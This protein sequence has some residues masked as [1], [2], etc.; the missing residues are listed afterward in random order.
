MREK[1]FESFEEQLKKTLILYL[2]IPITFFA[3][4]GYGIM[5][6]LGYNSIKHQN[7][8]NT[9][10][11]AEKLDKIILGYYYEINKISKDKDI[12]DV[13][14]KNN[15]NN[16]IYAK[17][18]DSINS[19]G[20]DGNFII[21]DKNCLPVMYSAS[22]ILGIDNAYNFQIFSKM[23]KHPYNIILKTN[24][25]Y[26]KNGNRSI[27]SIGKAII[28]DEKIIGFIIYNMLEKHLKEIIGKGSS[29]NIVVTDKYGNI[30]TTTN[31][32]FKNNLGKIN[33]ELR[34]SF[35]YRKMNDH[36][37]FVNR[38][39]IYKGKMILYLISETSY[40]VENYINGFLY[41]IALLLVI[42]ILMYYAAKI[43]SI[44]K[45]KSMKE[46]IDAI[47]RIKIGDLNTKLNVNSNDEFE[48]I[49]SSYNKMLLNIKNLIKINE[50]K[51]K[52]NTL[53][54]IKQ[55]ESQFNPHFLF[56]TLEMLRY[57]IK[58]DVLMANKIILNI[59]SLLRF[60][61]EN[62][63]TEV[64]LELN[65]HY[66]RNYLDIQKYR[67]G[68]NFDYV[69]DIK[70]E[71]NNFLIPKLIIQ[72]IIENAIK[73]GYRQIDKMIIYIRV[74]IIKNKLVITIYNNGQGMTKNI[75]SEVRKS[76]KK[77]DISLKKHI[78][79]YNIFRRIQLMYGE[80]YGIKILSS[81]KRGTSIRLYLPIKTRESD[82]K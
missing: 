22:K 37:Y 64:P 36:K 39:E 56:N 6:F 77:D 65:S 43:I 33:K 19:L 78:G 21:Y 79:I 66:T 67:F 14:I 82:E 24:K 8:K 63:Y 13:I 23:L 1:K 70:N 30:V 54:E 2:L 4:S 46:I 71:M 62:K 42:I 15:P 75:I 47:D 7:I 38:K 10:I 29:F 52:Y 41:L 50:E 5:Y 76:L 20:I 26:F 72:P 55:L 27:L 16:K 60:S 53:L 58:T 61:I 74:K 25:I 12:M 44:N 17:V 11:L 34:D 18:Y 73:H 80:E 57:T 68:Q 3:I 45:M 35:G 40:L 49:A 28:K 69:I 51:A 81:V 31:E 9:K 32:S 59:S 48:I